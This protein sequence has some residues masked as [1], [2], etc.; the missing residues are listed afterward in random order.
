MTALASITQDWYNTTDSGSPY[1]GVQVVFVD[2]RKAF[3]LV[4]HGVLLTK[5]AGMGISKSFWKWTQSYLSGR[6]Q[7][8]KLLGVLSRHGKVIAG[9]PQG[10]VISPTLFN[11]HIN[12]IEECIPSELPV[13]TCK[14]ADDCTLYKLVSIYKDSV[15][16]MQGAVTHLKNWAV[17]NKMELNAKKTKDMCITFKKSCPTV[18]PISIGPYMYILNWRGFQ[19]LNYWV[20]VYTWYVQNDIKWN[21]HVSSIVRKA[22]KWIHYLRVC[23]KALLPRDIGLTTYIAKIRPV[24]EYASPVWGGLPIYL[25]EEL[26]RVQNTVDV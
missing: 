26:Q 14:Y 4:D 11:V 15:S 16:Q 12:D 25:E 24:L 23:R 1:N 6:T 18:P 5:L 22:C 13:S 17:Q 9:V 3:Y 10:G 20:R 19:S 7:Q 21:T 8:V 2:F